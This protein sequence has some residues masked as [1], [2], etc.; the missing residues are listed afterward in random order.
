MNTKLIDLMDRVVKDPVGEARSTIK[1]MEELGMNK[2]IKFQGVVQDRDV[3]FDLY[4]HNEF[5]V[6][7]VVTRRYPNGTTGA[8]AGDTGKVMA[9]AS[10]NGFDILLVDVGEE[11]I[12][13]TWEVD[14]VKCELWFIVNAVKVN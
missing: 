12:A 6:G 1:S 10:K 5:K 8:R 3:G 14:G 2:V 7:D 13:A 9:V 11:S 4:C